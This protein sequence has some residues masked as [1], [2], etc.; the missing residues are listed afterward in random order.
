[1]VTHQLFTKKKNPIRVESGIAAD[2][3]ILILLFQIMWK[4]YFKRLWMQ[5]RMNW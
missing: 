4:K 5:A 2:K 1:M 3:F